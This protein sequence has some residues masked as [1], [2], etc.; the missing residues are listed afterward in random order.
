M[1]P[2]I[3]HYVPQFILRNFCFNENQQIYVFDKKTEKVFPTNIEN[4]AAEKGFYNFKNGEF[5]FSIENNLSNLESS[6][7]NAIERII[8]YESLSAIAKDEKLLL[9]L[10]IAAQF[11]RTKQQRILLKQMNDSIVEF[12]KKLGGDPNQVDGF[13]PLDDEGINKLAIMNVKDAIE[14]FAP[15]FYKRKWMLFKS[16]NLSKHYISDNP[17]TLHNANDFGPFGNL[18]LGVKGIE[19]YLPISPRLLIAIYDESNVEIIRTSYEKSKVLEAGNNSRQKITFLMRGLKT[20]NAVQ[21]D[22]E[23]IK[24]H[25]S[26][27]VKFA[28]RFIYSVDGNFDLVLEMLKVNPKFKEPPQMVTE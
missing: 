3:Q 22:N 19:V 20:G 9:S 21:L 5:T 13:T 23:N 25:N 12:V 14:S 18:G 11:S 8:K 27:Q 15:I 16:T 2:K 24:F 26:M 28:T 4:I 1:L 6:A 17:V 10:F 7:A